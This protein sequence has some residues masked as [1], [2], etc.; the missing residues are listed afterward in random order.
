MMNMEL[1]YNACRLSLRESTHIRG[2]KSGFVGDLFF[3]KAYM[4]YMIESFF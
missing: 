4:L 3:S 2:A 1:S